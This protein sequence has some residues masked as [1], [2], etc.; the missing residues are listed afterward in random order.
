MGYKYAG[1]EI[2]TNV[3]RRAETLDKEVLRKAIADTHMDTM[4]G[5]IQYNSEN[6]CRTP[7]VGG[8]RVKGDQFPWDVKIVENRQHPYIPMTGKIFSM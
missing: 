8:Q 2:A 7:L 5:H 3:L 6:Y 1:Y 4:V